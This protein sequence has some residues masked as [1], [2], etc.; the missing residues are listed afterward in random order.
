M[1]VSVTQVTSYGSHAGTTWQVM[2]AID[3]SVDG[4]VGQDQNCYFY[5]TS[6]SSFLTD[7]GRLGARP[8]LKRE[9]YFSRPIGTIKTVVF[10]QHKK[11]P[12]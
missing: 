2:C 9:T 12:G 5:Q 11:R 6:S 3:K 7:S 4:T 1:G 10:T 8:V